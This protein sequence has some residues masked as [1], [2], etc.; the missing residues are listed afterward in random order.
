MVFVE[1]VVSKVQQNLDL[2]LIKERLRF[3][4][5]FPLLKLTGPILS[6]VQLHSICIFL[7]IGLAPYPFLFPH[8]PKGEEI[9]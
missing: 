2:T 9:L 7:K 5:Q 3:E 4:Y 6:L 1:C 8:F